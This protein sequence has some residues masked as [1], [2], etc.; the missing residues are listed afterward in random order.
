[1]IDKDFCLSSYM[2]F[3]YIFKEG[4]DFFEGMKHENFKPLPLKTGFQ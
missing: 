4:V 3:R 2:A 1:M